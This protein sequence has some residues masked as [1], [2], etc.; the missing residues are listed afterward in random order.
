[1]ELRSTAGLVLAAGFETTVNL[2]SN[3]IR[4][5][6]DHPEQL[7][8]LKADPELWG[9]AVEEVLRLD[10]PVLLTGR[11]AQADTTVAGVPM[12]SGA[13]GTTLLAGANRDP[14]VFPPPERTSA[15]SGK[16]GSERI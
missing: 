2:L 5:L 11:M 9:N 3:G 15:G 7:A 12:R 14:K 16:N 1:M 10:P 4:L 13:L 6:H 8:L